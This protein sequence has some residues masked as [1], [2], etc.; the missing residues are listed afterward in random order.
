MGRLVKDYQ[1]QFISHDFFIEVS[2]PPVLE[3]SDSLQQTIENCWKEE[4]ERQGDQLFNGKLLSLI[5]YDAGHLVGYFVEY[6]RYIAQL[7]NP[8]LAEVLKIKPVC[9]CGITSSKD[10]L[11]IGLRSSTVTQYPSLYDLAPSG[12]VDPVSLEGNSI[13]LKKQL[14]Q[15][16]MEETGL[17]NEKVLSI[18]PFVLF[19]TFSQPCIE[20]CATIEMR[21][22]ALHLTKPAIEEYTE[23][24]WVEKSR[25]REFMTAYRHQF[26]PIAYYLL[27]LCV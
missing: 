16:L 2:S 10:H 13:N 17:S 26:V 3:L 12:G 6:K 15:E 22:E 11:L 8:N 9:V 7:R 25:L 19:D 18:K 27:E 5:S 21:P 14:E 4:K 20:I 23:L 24:L 1:T